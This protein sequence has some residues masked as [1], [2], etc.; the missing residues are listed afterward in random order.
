MRVS[1][2]YNPSA[3]G[4]QDARKLVA[5]L[6]AAGHQVRRRSRKSRWREIL[7]DPGDVLVAAGGDGTVRDV[8]LAAAECG[9]PFAILPFG[10]ANNVAKTLG[11]VGDTHAAIRRWEQPARPFDIGELVT[12]G[13]PARFV[14]SVGGG[15]FADLIGELRGKSDSQ[16]LLGRET[17][18]ALH[19]LGRLNLGAEA[20]PWEVTV[21]GRD[22]SGEYLAVE[23][24]NVA[25]A[26]PNVPIAPNADPRDGQLDVVFIGPQ[27]RHALAVYLD[28]RLRLASGTLPSFLVQP[29][30]RIELRAPAGTRLRVDD[31]LL[32]DADGRVSLEVRCGAAAARILGS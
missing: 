17:D 14:E 16:S 19:V 1:L 10:M 23:V 27:H 29:G 4:A 26:G 3:G 11:I 5:L 22:C 20:R 21:D 13:P 9:V 32:G 8:A 12:P 15:I 30:T 7:Q 24:L 6:T 2:V 18:R 25:F 31:E 28:A